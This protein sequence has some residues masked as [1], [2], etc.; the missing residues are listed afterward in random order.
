MNWFRFYTK[1]ID[2]PKIQ[3]LSGDLFKA[4]V[5]LLCLA[6]LNEGGYIGSQSFVAFRLR[7]SEANTK[8]WVAELIE[9]KLLDETPEGI[10][11]HD[12]EEYQYPSDNPTKRVQKFRKKRAGNVSVTADVTPRKRF[13]NGTEE[14][15]VEENRNG[16]LPKTSPPIENLPEKQ[17]PRSTQYPIQDLTEVS[18]TLIQFPGAERLPGEPDDVI[19]SKCLDLAGGDVER[20]GGALRGMYLA[21]KKPATSWA[22]F[23]VVVGQYLERKRA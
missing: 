5:N 17:N 15:R 6:R 21:R 19:L 8:A 2:N 13:G 10:R 12:W 11:P 1:S 23:P 16:V 14:N 7:W 4:W 3:M 20:L 18:R 22:W 9:R